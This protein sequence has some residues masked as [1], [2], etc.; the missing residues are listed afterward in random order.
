LY[1]EAPPLFFV[2]ASIF[3]LSTNLEIGLKIASAFIVALQVP[4]FFISLYIIKG[5]R[6]AYFTLPFA[7][8][9]TTF[10]AIYS[11]LS[12]NLIGLAFIRVILA[13]LWKLWQK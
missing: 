3:S 2:I 7:V 4:S 5:R 6:K 13:A 11:N 9:N 1:Y 10:Y 12:K 8:W